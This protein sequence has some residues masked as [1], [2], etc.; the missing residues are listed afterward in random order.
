MT[1]SSVPES[2]KILTVLALIT[3]MILH[4]KLRIQLPLTS[5]NNFEKTITAKYGKFSTTCLYL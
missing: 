2:R 1:K 5:I 3:S 4:T